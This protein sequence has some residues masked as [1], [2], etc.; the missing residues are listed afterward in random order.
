MRTAIDPISFF[1]PL[2]I[3]TD[4]IFLSPF[5]DHVYEPDQY[6]TTRRRE[7]KEKESLNHDTLPL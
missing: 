3:S 5:I 6:H 2:F 4:S 7:K 1:S